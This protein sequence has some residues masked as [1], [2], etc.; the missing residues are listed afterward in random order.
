MFGRGCTIAVGLHVECYPDRPRLDIYYH[1]IGVANYRA[2]L[3]GDAFTPAVSA[4]YACAARLNAYVRHPIY[5]SGLLILPGLVLIRPSLT[6]LL[7]SVMVLAWLYAQARLEEINLIQRLA[8][9]QDYMRDVPRFIPRLRPVRTA[10]PITE[11]SV[12]H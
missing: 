8:Q 12:D 3:R 11:K 9:Y 10:R 4:P 7:V 2:Y 1:W 5:A 6:V